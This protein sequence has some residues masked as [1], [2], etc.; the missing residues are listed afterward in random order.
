MSPALAD[1][2]CQERQRNRQANLTVQDLVQIA[3][4]RVVVMLG[5]ASETALLEEKCRQRRGASRERTAQ[6]RP[7]A[8]G[9][10]IDAA[11]RPRGFI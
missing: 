7:E 1:R 2:H 8:V 3:V 6:A 10:A 9:Q 5:V 4:A 11:D